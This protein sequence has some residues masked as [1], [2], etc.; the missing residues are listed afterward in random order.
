MEELARILGD[1]QDRVRLDLAPAVALAAGAAAR[2]TPYA[3]R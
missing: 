3:G 1:D 2:E